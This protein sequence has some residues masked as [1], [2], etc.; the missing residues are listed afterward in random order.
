[1]IADAG[2][3]QALKNFRYTT[4]HRRITIDT[5]ACGGL[6]LD[7]ERVMQGPHEKT[8]DTWDTFSGWHTDDLKF[9][10]P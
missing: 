1:M 4:A 2:E 9:E 6:P 10:N 8:L 3:I 5:G 7:H